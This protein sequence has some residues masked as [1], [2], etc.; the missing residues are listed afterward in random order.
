MNNLKSI[1]F[2]CLIA[3]MVLCHSFVGASSLPKDDC[4][5]I[6]EKILQLPPTGG[7]VEVPSGA[8][9][10]HSPIILDRSHL[11]LKG[12][13]DV[14]IRLA[15]NA[16]APVIIMGDAATPPRP[17][18]DIQVSN[19]QIDGNRWHQKYECWGGYCDTGGTT[20]VR[21][22]GIT[23][24]GVTNGL[25]KDVYITSTRSGGVVT[26]RGCFDLEIDNLTS[27]DNEFD[28]FAGYETFGARLTRLNLSH[29]QA[30]GI[31]LDIRF[32]GNIMRDVK[33]ENNGDVGR[34]V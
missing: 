30:A 17:L 10:C 27:V 1:L 5:F 29:N 28:G 14:K 32:H 16:N 23:V 13:G 34:M 15:K 8:Y 31:S 11:R 3:L 7:E 33:I 18:R 6:R 19:L 22:N 25:I 24:R 2:V 20:F 26:E 21:N 12:Q 4:S 9:A